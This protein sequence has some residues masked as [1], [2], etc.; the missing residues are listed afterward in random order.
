MV[1]NNPHLGGIFN[2]TSYEVPVDGSSKFLPASCNR[3]D[4]APRNRCK[5][6]QVPPGKWHSE[7]FPWASVELAMQSVTWAER[8]NQDNTP[9]R[10]YLVPWPASQKRRRRRRLAK[11]DGTHAPGSREVGTSV[12]GNHVHPRNSMTRSW[13]WRALD[14]PLI[15][16]RS[17]ESDSDGKH[18]RIVHVP[19]QEKARR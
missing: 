13:N 6:K 18:A 15:S 14:P 12:Q 1:G 9:F 2:G 3:F 7:N 11:Q 5:C 8:R 17:G 10:R 19:R 16:P 4:A